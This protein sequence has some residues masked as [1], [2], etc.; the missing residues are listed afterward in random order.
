MKKRITRI[1]MLAGIAL[2][3][4]A[5]PL[6][7]ANAGNMSDVSAQATTAATVQG[8]APVVTSGGGL[9]GPNENNNNNTNQDN[10]NQ[11][12]TK[13]DDKKQ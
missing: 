7:A 1:V 3:Y 13:K 6:I 11:D 2:G 8:V 4:G 12:N 5:S 9:P 10:T